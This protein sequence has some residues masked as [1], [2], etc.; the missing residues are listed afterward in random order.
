MGMA[1]CTPTAHEFEETITN[2]N[3]RKFEETVNNVTNDANCNYDRRELRD[4]LN[5][6]LGHNPSGKVSKTQILTLFLSHLPAGSRLD[7]ALLEELVASLDANHDGNI[8]FREALL[9]LSAFMRGRP[10]AKVQMLFA[11]LDVDSS[12]SVSKAELRIA[13]HK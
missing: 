4:L 11:A 12:G 8:G 6:W 7:E 2:T 13:L 9:G 5:T 10:E 3:T 1:C